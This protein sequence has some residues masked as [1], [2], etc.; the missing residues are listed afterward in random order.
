VEIERLQADLEAAKAQADAE[1]LRVKACEHIAEGDE[2]WEALQNECPSTAAVAKLRREVVAAERRGA[3]KE[4]EAIAIHFENLAADA[5]V[6]SATSS[7]QV[8]AELPQRS[9]LAAKREG[10]NERHEDATTGGY[11]DI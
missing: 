11:M 8:M 5:S 6:F 1:M 10:R 3:N 7:H 9:V 2:G 4:R